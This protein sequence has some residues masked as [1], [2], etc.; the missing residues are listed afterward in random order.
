MKVYN[1][2]HKW[3]RSHPDIKTNEAATKKLNELWSLSGKNQAVMRMIYREV[4]PK[5]K[6]LWLLDK[7]VLECKVFHKSKARQF[8]EPK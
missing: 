6:N 4:R 7:L 1:S 3:L 8:K 2:L 5:H